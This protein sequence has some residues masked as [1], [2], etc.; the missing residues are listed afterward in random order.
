MKTKHGWVQC[1]L[2]VAALGWVANIQSSAATIT[3]TST[4][5]SGAGSLRAA[6]AAA[7]S[8]DT[9]QFD[10]SLDGKTITLT[11]GELD[12]TAAAKP[13]Y[14]VG[15][16]ASQLTIK[17][18]NTITPVFHVASTAT[19]SISG[20]TITGGYDEC[21]YNAGQLTIINCTV[22]YATGTSCYGIDFDGHWGGTLLVTGCN[23]QSNVN[24]AIYFDGSGGGAMTVTNSTLSGNYLGI[25]AVGSLSVVMSCIVS[26][27]A[28]T[29]NSN[30]GVYLQY[31]R[32]VTISSST[33]S[34]NSSSGINN[35]SGA[36]T[37]Y[38][39]TIA[40][41]GAGTAGQGGGINNTGTLIVN[42]STI[43]RN[44]A[45]Y[46]G[47]GIYQDQYNGSTTLA[48]T[49]VA[50]N[51]NGTSPDIYGTVTANY[52]LIGNTTDPISLFATGSGN[53]IVN[54]DPLMAV[55]GNYLGPTLTMALL[56]GSPGIDKG[57][58]ALI[59]SGLTTD[60][61]GLS[62]VWPTNGTVDIGAYEYQPVVTNISPTTGPTSGGTTVNIT[63]MDLTGATAVDFGA[64]PATDVVTNSATQITATSP[65][66][67]AG[68][69]DVTIVTPFGT[70]ATSSADHFTYFLGSTVT[71]LVN[72]TNDG[73]AYGGGTYAIGT[74]IQIS[75]MASTGW[76]FTDWN[77]GSTNN[78]Y[79]ITVAATN[80]TY[81]ANFAQIS[82]LTVLANP[83][84]GGSVTGG[85]TFFVGSNVVLTATTSNNWLF[86]QWNDGV[87]TNARTITIP[88]TNITYTAYFGAAATL[89]VSD[90]TNVGGTVTGSGKFLLGST[91]WITATVSNGWAFIGWS[92]GNT[93]SNRSIVVASNVTYTAN[94]AP[95]ALITVQANPASGGTVSGGGTYIVGSNATIS[96]TVSNL[97][98]F[99]SWDDGSVTNNPWTLVVPS[100]GATHTAKFAPLGAVTASANPTNGGSVAGGGFYLIGSNATVTAMASNRWIFLNWNSSITN[101][102]WIFMV[103]SNG[104]T[105]TANFAQ[106]SVVTALASPTN[107]GSVS[108]GGTNIVGSNAV[109]TATASNSWLFTQWKDGV[110]NNPRSVVVP[111]TNITYT[112]T[113]VQTAGVAV[114]VN[115][116]IGG[117]VTGSGVYDVGS[118]A[119]LTATASNGW[120]FTSWNDSNTSNPRTIV[121]TAGGG[122]YT[123]NFV[124]VATLT[125]LANP[126]NAGSVSGGGLYAIGGM[127]SI[128]AP[129][130]LSWRFLRWSDGNPTNARAYLVVSNITLTANFTNA[131]HVYMQDQVGNVT[132]WTINNTGTLQQY[133]TFGGMGA[134]ILKGIGDVTHDG[135]ADLFWQMTSGWVVAYLSQTNSAYLG[136]GL[137]N[138]GAWTLSAVADVDGDGI[139]DLIWQLQDP[140]NGWITVW[141]MKSNCTQRSAYSLGNLGVWRLKGAGDINGDGK[142]DLILQTPMG[143]V[144]VWLSQ[145]GGGYQGLGV[146]NL[147]AWEL[148]TVHDVD[149]DGIADL[150]WQ[151]PGGWTV[152]WYMNS[153]GVVRAGVGL[154]NIFIGTTTNKI[155]AVE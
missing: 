85:G 41:N 77:D 93:N 103:V 18:V 5:D 132:K 81:T 20:L 53:N 51:M 52:C 67:T 100:G 12:I 75:A 46:Y 151:N 134:W 29:G 113:F 9:I 144:V 8:G 57:S 137:G 98:R 76:L 43:A 150:L 42:D 59:P 112:A 22:S 115:T 88:P 84:N 65:A 91:N 118:N 15:P 44:S 48:N 58:N 94:F 90:N 68:T 123:A 124:P 155:M 33:I 130:N 31:A 142:A 23:I 119:V 61:R 108:G 114:A 131:A 102:P 63:G 106:I 149:G 62:R 154:G 107:A 27:C 36:L 55:L 79:T 14:I 21:I 28:I 143:D 71:L 3:V 45:T 6:I 96:A 153:N 72:P 147:G 26:G 1:G 19:A 25:T 99:I 86:T 125:L 122:S 35:S 47:G 92:D 69:V 37:I 127:A 95:T 54:Q 4:N 70:S 78:P 117:S 126:T 83:T 128:A 152:A 89:T 80:I 60:Q 97:W 40:D 39:C 140:K 101:N 34:G 135:I 139:A 121:V 138:L 64:T 133:A 50:G 66:S 13:L 30:C 17:R 32:G 136:V 49:I 141:L 16:G 38:D 10:P 2:L 111:P 109:L 82:T 146:G 11:S 110:T 129:A 56:P 120:I 105:C 24:A 145:P 148:R 104:M 7:G 116:N 74:N 87:S 73:S